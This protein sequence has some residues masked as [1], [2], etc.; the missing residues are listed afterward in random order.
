MFLMHRSAAAS[1]LAVRLT[2]RARR[3]TLGLGWAL[4]L[5]ACGGSDFV[6]TPAVEAPPVVVVAPPAS[7]PLL[8][9]HA[10]FPGTVSGSSDASTALALDA[11]WML[12][13]DDESNVLSVYPRSGGA[14]VA[15]WDY[16]KNGPMLAKELDL[17]ASAKVKD[18]LYLIG[19]HS[20][21]KDG[22][23][24]MADRG[25]LFEVKIEGTGSATRV[26]YVGKFSDLENQLVAWD[27]G[28]AHGL[29]ADHFG[30]ANSAAAGITPERVDGFS[31]EGLVGAP[32]DS[33]L[34]LGFRAPLASAG[35]RTSAL[36]VPLTNYAA[37][38]AGT[39]SAAAFGT[40]IE[41]DLGG[42]G[43]RAI[44]RDGSGNYLII[45]G[46]AGAS[47]P[48]LAR[49]FALFGWN[50]HPSSAPQEFD[51]DLDALRRASAGSF[52]T[53]VA[54]DGPVAPGASVQLLMDNGDTVWPG[55]TS[56]SKDLPT[57]EQQFQGYGLQLGAYRV[58]I[59]GPLL[60]VATPQDDR[61]G[62]PVD[63]RIVLQF[64][65]ALKLG[66]GNLTL[67]RADGSA[68]EVFNAASAAGRIQLATNQVTLTPS[69]NL[70]H[71]TT[72]HLT[73]D[74]NA[75]TDGKGNAYA[76]IDGADAFNFMSA[77]QATA[78]AIDDLLF[79]G[80]NAEAPDAIAFTFL[81]DISGGTQVTFSDRDYLLATKFAGISNEGVFRWTADRD[82]KA[83]TIVTIQTD[84][85]PL[86][87]IA[88]IGTTLGAPAGIGK[89][90]VIY[91]MVGT[92]VTMLA[93]GGA[94]EILDPG[95]FLASITLGGLGTGGKSP[96]EI[97]GELTSAGTAMDFSIKP[98][99]QTNAIYA[100]SFDRSNMASFA[101][102]IKLKANWD[103]S[104]APAPGYP[105]TG[106]SMFAGK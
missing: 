68:V 62:V 8:S 41:L 12:V 5:A 106:G 18:A 55:K 20:N 99:N 50:G 95:R 86:S 81:K 85:A 45:A 49:N 102:R 83:G 88:D 47:N 28:D 56:V 93:D 69:Q 64:D 6:G 101:A 66:A 25:H 3:A 48:A 61:V 53:I 21:K 33:A 30:F 87:P 74:G 100:G 27:R 13:G 77:G 65:E 19:S 32:N 54:L 59:Q 39:A 78:L 36:I 98:A 42:R 104:H 90:E 58:D 14:A 31:I 96:R 17:E 82:I 89:E 105:L 63:A 52:E 23:D 67:R 94:G 22:G 46:P 44:E 75:L 73:I 43:I 51:N 24:A 29:G 15:Q 92:V 9:V 11:S 34:W 97:P 80:A 4:G 57:A 16:S 91:A 38:V 70:D 79:V 60:K 76:G 35:A 72:Y 103:V 7:L 71:L 40:P 26:T 37:L 1:A 2:G 84:T 10:P